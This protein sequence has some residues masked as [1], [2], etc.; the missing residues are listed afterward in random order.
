[1]AV[2]QDQHQQ[3]RIDL[4]KYEK[5]DRKQAGHL[6]HFHN[7]VDQMDGD[8]HGMGSQQDAHQ[9]FID[10]YRYQL[11]QMSYG[12][13]VAH[14]HRLPAARSVFKPL[15]RRII[16]KMLRPEVWGYWYLTSQSGS[17]VDPDLTELRKPWA[18][19]VAAENIMYSGHL[20]LMTSLYAMLFDDD[21]FEKPGSIAFTWAPIFWGFGPE[22]YRYDNRSLQTAIVTQMERNNWVGVCCEPNSVFVVC[23]QFPL[24]A[25]RYNDVR[26][27]V[28]TVSHVL[29][30]YSKAIL[31]RG[32]LGRDGLYPE[33]LYLKQGRL[34]PPKGVTSAAWANAFM[35]AWNTDFVY[36]SYDKQAFGFIMPVDGA[37]RLQDPAV[38]LEFRKLAQTE[39]PG[40]YDE[41]ALLDKARAEAAKLPPNP[42]PLTAPYLGYVVLWLSELGKEKELGDLLEYA[43]SRLQP[44]WERGGLFY[45]RN[46]TTVNDKGDWVHIDPFTG[47]AA[48]GYARLN[49]KDGQKIM[50][51]KPWTRE[52][53]ASRPWVDQVSL[54]QGVDCLR[55]CWDD[56]EKLLVLT[57]RTWDDGSVKV[58]PVARN[59]SAGFW[60]VYVQ[61]ELVRRDAVEDGG[62]L[63][64]DVEVTGNDLD[65]V[66]LKI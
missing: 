20:L 8:W 17:F 2:S 40:G 49:V 66:F 47:N 46:N 56:E 23:N 28:D 33:W 45:P 36:S 58:Q 57:L 29:E 55:A 34:V 43:D 42:F 62:S 7:L 31:D 48:I 63:S 35:N 32:L 16:H 1:M 37:F 10:A 61:G 52:T 5:L 9:E 38:A 22:T 13:A 60:G 15:L 64:V 65:I 4:S 25:M 39:G 30:K 59:L 54:S 27:G 3:L 41:T 26:D 11:A 24:I 14:Y 50:W 6:R 53:L 44:T 51:D 12:A 19:P 21:E 18:D